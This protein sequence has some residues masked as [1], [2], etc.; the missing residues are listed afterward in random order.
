MS[1]ETRRVL[2]QILLFITTCV[3]TTL[4]GAEWAYSKFIFHID[5]GA[6]IVWNEDYS[7]NDFMMGMRFS[8]PFLLILTV[9]EFG[10]YFTAIYN[11]VKTSL[12]YYIPLPPG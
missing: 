9:H 7:W 6:G 4:A 12:P 3:T 10:H 1:K 5:M 2:L 11:K 8:I